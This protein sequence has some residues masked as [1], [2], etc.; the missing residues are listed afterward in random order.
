MANKRR[1][2][3]WVRSVNNSW[4]ADFAYRREAYVYR[5]LAGRF[6][7]KQEVYQLLAEL[8]STFNNGVGPSISL[9]LSR[10]NNLS[11][12][13]AVTPSKEV[14]R[15]RG[16]GK[17]VSKLC[18]YGVDNKCRQVELTRSK[19][20]VGLYPAVTVLHEFAHYLAWKWW[21]DGAHNAAW[22]SIDEALHEWFARKRAHKGT[23]YR[24]TMTLDK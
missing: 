8:A 17:A 3:K 19:V 15:V 5:H 14:I 2:R 4:Q 6:M 22:A 24:V 23:K 9:Y 11:G 12:H 7:T 21:C 16:V 20:P 13:F 1:V 18:W 10:R